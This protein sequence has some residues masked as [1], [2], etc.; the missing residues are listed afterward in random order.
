[1]TFS[2]GSE[3]KDHIP[4]RPLFRRFLTGALLMLVF[5]LSGSAATEE[6]R[7]L[8]GSV[9]FGSLTV[10][11]NATHIDLGDQ[12]VRDYDSFCDFLDR[13][14]NLEWCDMFATKIR[15]KNIDLL[16]ERYPDILFGWTMVI[17]ASDHSQHLLRTDATAFSTLHNSSVSH[18]TSADFEILKYCPDLLALDIGHNDVDDLSFLSCLPKL[19]V[20]IVACCQVSDITPIAQ[21]KDLQYLELFKNDI[22]DISALSGLTELIDLNICFN[23]IKDWTPLTGLNKLQRLWLYNSNNYSEEVPVPKAVVEELRSA[24]QD[25][26]VDSV[27]YSTLGGWREHER[28]DI[29]SKMFKTGQ[30]IPFSEKLPGQTD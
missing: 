7:P 14:P 30:Y 24:L 11:S 4:I 27:S 28:Y 23:R 13:L 21:L 17:P 19:R 1:M 10:S 9:T 8:S 6:E 12:V 20:L 18:H 25:C 2:F 26:C 15:R 5:I 29:V 3:N 22:H 16:A